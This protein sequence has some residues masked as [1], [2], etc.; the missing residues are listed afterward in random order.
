MD[1]KSIKARL[2]YLF[3]YNALHGASLVLS[4]TNVHARYYSDFYDVDSRKFRRVLVG[5]DD[6]V[7]Y[8]RRTKKENDCFLVI[9]WGG[10]IPLQ[11]VKY[12]LRAAKLL[13]SHK[14]VKFELR[15]L[16]QTYGEALELSKSLKVKNLTFVPSWLS[17][18]NIPNF[19]AKADVCVGIFGE[20]EKAQRVIPNKAVEALAMQKP[21]ITGDSPAAREI[22][23]NMEN[24]LL[25]PMANPEALA[26]AI[27]TL[28]EDH[29]LREKIAENGYRVF[30]EKLSPKAIGK[31]LK[32]VLVE[33]TE[34]FR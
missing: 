9:F 20:T 1:D 29:K 13:E 18:N 30:K 17:Y 6:E 3:D 10:F 5:S 33:L 7:F 22:L 24:S 28:K 21:L 15:G 27:L 34:K 32:S 31:E 11:G 8:P 25:V 16:G 4:D 26:G 2:L 12:I 19:I 23:V 14:D